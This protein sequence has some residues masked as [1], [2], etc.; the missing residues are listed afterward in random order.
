SGM[1]QDE[2]HRCQ[3]MLEGLQKAISELPKGVINERKK[4]YRDKAYSYH[5]LKYREGK[6]V[7]NKHIAEKD[8]QDILKKLKLR[9]KYEKEI[10]SY[11]KKIAYLNK[12]LSPGRSRAH[13]RHGQA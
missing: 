3:E 10:Q 11:K 12:I 5:Y 4:Q 6:R 2:L 1:L 9:K 13:A 8:L 7:F